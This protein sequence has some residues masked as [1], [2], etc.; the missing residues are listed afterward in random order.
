MFHLP[1]KYLSNT[2]GR[3]RHIEGI[4]H[5]GLG[6]FDTVFWTVS[7]FLQSAPRLSSPCQNDEKF[8]SIIGFR[9]SF[10]VVSFHENRYFRD[11]DK[12][13]FSKTV[14]LKFCAI[15]ISL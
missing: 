14:E 12:Q 1:E 9:L 11:N 8:A 3:D 15:Q 10:S 5:L 7:N 4:S 6:C 2:G 13:N